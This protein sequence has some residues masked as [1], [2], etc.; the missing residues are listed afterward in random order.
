MTLLRR[1]VV[2][3]AVLSTVWGVPTV[4]QAMVPSTATVVISPLRGPAGTLVQVEVSGFPANAQIDL[5]AGRVDQTYSPLAVSPTDA[6]GR[7]NIQLAIPTYAR[8]GETWVIVAVL[9]ENP[10]VKAISNVFAVT[11][12]APASGVTYSVQPGDNL[13]RIAQRFGTT[14]AALLAANPGISN[15]RLIFAGQQLV[16]PGPGATPPTVSITP[17]RGPPGTRVQIAAGGFT[18]NTP[19]EL[20]VGPAGGPLQT[21]DTAHTTASTGTLA[22]QFSIPMSA[23]PGQL[24]VVQVTTADDARQS[25]LSN[26]FSVVAA[27]AGSAPT[28]YL[29][30]SG[31]NLSRIAYRFGTTVQALLL[32]N[33]TIADPRLI[34]VGQVL[35]IPTG[36]G[37]PATVTLTPLRGAAGSPVQVNASG[38]PANAPVVIE[39]GPASAQPVVTYVG[40]ATDAA[41]RLATTVAVPP[42]ARIGQ[43][44]TAVVRT[45]G[46]PTI[47]AASN[48]FA[49]T[50]GAG[51]QPVTS[52]PVYLVA[53]DQGQIGC[54]DAL[55]AV[56]RSVPAG[57]QPW[58]AAIEALLALDEPTVSAAALYNALAASDLRLASMEVDPQ[59][60][61]VIQLAGTLHLGGV[62]DAPRIA[63]QLEQTA[64]QFPAIRQVA[65]FVNGQP[66]AALLNSQGRTVRLPY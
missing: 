18:P 41:G 38:F 36:L 59:G 21:V 32:A 52:V 15:P 13:S 60:A 27:E 4:A 34:Y 57:D 31:D 1:S 19:V 2:L 39:V 65:V 7:L 14:V 53:L 46:T 6:Q 25:A 17:L 47:A 22:A 8:T 64:L 50:Q 54:G 44:W 48:V 63:A 20:A 24:W 16:I 33:P 55:R 35:T 26:V 12:P 58:R 51:S 43:L 66:L 23:A 11:G 3:L 28:V 62:C 9:S 40:Q 45:T 30:R 10:G 29:V 49:V 56:P 37:Q 42:S 5:S 61:A